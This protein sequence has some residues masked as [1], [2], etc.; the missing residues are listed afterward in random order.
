[1]EYQRKDGTKI[2][3]TTLLENE[4]KASIFKHFKKRQ[5]N[6]YKILTIALDNDRDSDVK[7]VVYQKQDDTKN[8]FIRES[9]DFFAKI[10]KAEYP[11]IE[12]EYRFQ[13]QDILKSE[14]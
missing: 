13:L 3:F 9:E 1:M 5:N 6:L 4:E 8:C 11:D 7:F 10:N 12:Q 2:E 14:K